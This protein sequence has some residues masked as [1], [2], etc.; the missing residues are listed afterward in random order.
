MSLVDKNGNEV[1]TGDIVWGKN[2]SYIFLQYDGQFVELQTTDDRRMF[3][4]V[5]PSWVGLKESNNA[6]T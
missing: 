1:K 2:K 5:I 4:R 3:V 6:S